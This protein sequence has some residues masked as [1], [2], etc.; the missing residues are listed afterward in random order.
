MTVIRAA[1]TQATWTGDEASMVDKHEALARQAAA[2]GAQIVCFQELFHGPYFG[3]VEDAK[4][5]E[6]AQQVPGPLTERF[7]ALA[8][9][10]GVVIVL[11]VYE[12]EMPGL[13]YNTAAVLDAD[14]SYLGKYRK[15]HIPNLDRFWEKFY[16]RPGNLGYPVFDTAVGKVGVYICYDRHFPEGWRELGLGG[17]E[18][19]FNPSATKPGLSNRLW[20]LEQPA[21]AAANQYFVAANNRIGTESDEFGDLA[22]TFYGSSY[23]VDPRGNLVGD[24]G[25]TDTE[26][27][28]I[29]DLDLGLVRQVRNDWQF[30][31]DRRPD[32]YTAIP[33][34]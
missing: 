33:A 28:V 3:I 19:V 31:R 1:I 30:Y 15:H 18:L 16:F 29:R 10:L 14:G 7:G 20:E 22:V 26:E 32:S 25:S 21:A 4:Y 23:F 2:D 11:P 8:K 17:A 27:I 13:Y 9:E 5:Y 24:A 34:R 6:Y 12:E